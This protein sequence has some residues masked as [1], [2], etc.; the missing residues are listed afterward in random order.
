MIFLLFF[1]LNFILNNKQKLSIPPP[2]ANRISHVSLAVQKPRY[3]AIELKR[4]Y[5]LTEMPCFCTAKEM[6]LV[7]NLFLR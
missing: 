6:H 3:F 4:L 5:L 7:K 2:I 1:I